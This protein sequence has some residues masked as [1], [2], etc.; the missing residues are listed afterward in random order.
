VTHPAQS[1]E[2]MAA[3]IWRHYCLRAVLALGPGRE[4][5]TGGDRG[6]Y[7]HS[8]LVTAKAMAVASLIREQKP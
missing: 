5:G 1:P 8:V 4:S 7:A 2:E 6:A 3:A